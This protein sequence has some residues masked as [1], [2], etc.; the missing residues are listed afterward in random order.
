MMTEIVESL[1][2]TVPLRV[3]SEVELT[4]AL[5]MAGGT[6]E[7]DGLYLVFQTTVGEWQ[8]WS[9]HRSWLCGFFV[10][11]CHRSAVSAVERGFV[12]LCVVSSG[13]VCFVFLS[14]RMCSVECCGPASCQICRR[15][16]WRRHV[17][18]LRG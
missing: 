13:E 7:S 12:R 6:Q 17:V 16:W 3:I 1:S 14:S 10:E 11:R 9:H 8:R 18:S 15:K 2:L 4:I 5:P